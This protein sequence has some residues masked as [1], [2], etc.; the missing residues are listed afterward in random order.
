MSANDLGK[1]FNSNVIISFVGN[2]LYFFLDIGP[3]EVYVSD[4]YTNE[5]LQFS[6]IELGIKN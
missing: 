4:I 6:L 1:L 2:L 5:K 3:G